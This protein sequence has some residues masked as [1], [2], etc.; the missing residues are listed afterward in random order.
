MTDVRAKHVHCAYAH[1]H[2]TG[3]GNK[4]PQ[5]SRY[6]FALSLYSRF[7]PSHNTPAAHA[8]TTYGLVLRHALG[9]SHQMEPPRHGVCWVV[10][11]GSG[12]RFRNTGR[13]NYV[14]DL[15]VHVP[16]LFTIYLS[17]HDIYINDVTYVLLFTIHH[18]QIKSLPFDIKPAWLL[19]TSQS[20]L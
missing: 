11:G 13:K 18:M 2:C 9:L 6:V 19:Q 16:I 20:F 4:F 12:L 10:L 5:I 14:R 8:R 1:V 15:T 3:P 7:K 17:N